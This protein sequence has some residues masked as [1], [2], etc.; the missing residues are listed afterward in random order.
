MSLKYTF[1]IP[2]YIMCIQ[3]KYI[4]V[5]ICLFIY[6]CVCV[7]VCVCVSRRVHNLVAKNRGSGTPFWN[8]L[9]IVIYS[10]FIY[11]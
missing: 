7:C 10:R 1:P 5:R 4:N 9:L 3:K 6:V 8:T 2:L 11:F